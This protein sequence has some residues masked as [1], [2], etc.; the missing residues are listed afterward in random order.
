MLDSMHIHKPFE[1][2]KLLMLG[3]EAIPESAKLM[4]LAWVLENAKI[5]PELAHR[6]AIMLVK[7]GFDSPEKLVGI[8]ENDLLACGIVSRNDVRVIIQ[9]GLQLGS[10]LTRRQSLQPRVNSGIAIT[11]EVQEEQQQ[12]EALRAEANRLMVAAAATAVVEEEQRLEK[13]QQ[14]ER[15]RLEEEQRL[16]ELEKQL[17]RQRLEELEELER[18]RRPQRADGTCS[19][20]QN[21]DIV[22][23]LD[24]IALDAPE[25]VESLEQLAG[26]IIKVVA[27]HL[28]ENPP[29]MLIEFSHLRVAYRWIA[30]HIAYSFQPQTNNHQD[31]QVLATGKANA[32][33]F[34]T[35]LVNLCTLLGVEIRTCWGYTKQESFQV[36]DALTKQHCWN[37][38]LLGAKR[39]PFLLD[40]MMSAGSMAGGVLFARKWHSHY[41][42]CPSSLFFWDHFPDDFQ[43]Q[44]LVHAFTRE[45]F[46]SMPICKPNLFVS[47]LELV[48]HFEHGVVECKLDGEVTMQFKLSWLDWKIVSPIQVREI[49]SGEVCEKCPPAN[50]KRNDQGEYVITIFPPPVCGD[51]DLTLYVVSPS[52]KYYSGWAVSY[53]LRVV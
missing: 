20:L 30:Q 19:Y 23:L 38:A 31:E 4:E 1:R 46:C 3:K 47:Q 17:E 22:D 25:R 37:L 11:V 33:G 8:L 45:Q 53:L 50:L 36:G 40:V 16:E 18:R 48:S 9:L 35:L 28:P 6:Y 51:F 43:D 41:F 7:Q 5:L 39:K 44:L 12:L 15:Q 49:G 2:R 13:E 29:Q 42:L 27:D 32:E 24:E 21:A 52:N 10:P 34:A 14:L 26:H